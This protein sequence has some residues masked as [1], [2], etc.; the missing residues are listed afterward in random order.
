MNPRM[1]DQVDRRRPVGAADVRRHRVRAGAG[2]RRSLRELAAMMVA[3]VSDGAASGARIDGVDVAGK[4]GTAENGSGQPYTLWFTGF[5][6]ADEPAGRRGGRGRRRRR[7]GPVGQRQHDRSP[8]REEGHGG[9]AGTD[10]TDAG[11]DLRRPLR[12]GLADRHRRHGRGVG[13]DRPRHRPHRRHQDPQR[14]VH[15]RPGLPRALPRRGPPRRA[16]QP[17]GHRERLRLRRG[18]RQRV[19]RHGA[20]ARRGALDDPRARRV[21]LDRQDPRH[22]RADLLRAAGRPRGRSRPPRHQARA[23]C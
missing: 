7:S 4:T 5:A 20:R 22:R 17:R 14:R 3:N 12:A 15:G 1:V 23:T 10:E 21:A 11:S 16:R 18:G 6:P 19:P 8:H 13:G 2:R 9:G